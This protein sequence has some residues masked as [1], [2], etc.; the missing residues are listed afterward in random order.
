[1]TDRKANF[2]RVFGN[3]KDMFVD[4]MRKLG[5]CS[6]KS[7]YQWDDALV[8]TCFWT[9]ATALAAA[10]DKFGVHLTISLEP[11]DDSNS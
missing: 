1:M 9:M 7:N 11:T 8:R 2:A 4:L 5:N 6:D 3:R 10:A